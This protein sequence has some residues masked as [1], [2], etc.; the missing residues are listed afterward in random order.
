MARHGDH[1]EGRVIVA[2]RRST[3]AHKVLNNDTLLLMTGVLRSLLP[4][5]ILDH[6]LICLLGLLLSR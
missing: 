4:T 6:S 5:C 2:G 3:T 1:S